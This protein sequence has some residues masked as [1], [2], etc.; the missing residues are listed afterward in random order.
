MNS[1]VLLCAI[2]G[3]DDAY[4]RESEQFSAIADGIAADRKRMRQRLTM[5]GVAAAVCLAVFGAVRLAPSVFRLFPPSE[6][7]GGQTPEVPASSEYT[8]SAVIRGE[9]TEKETA[10]SAVS[11]T[12]PAADKTESRTAPAG[13]DQ[14]APTSRPD[15]PAPGAEQ[16]PAETPSTTKAAE[17]TTA[18]LTTP[19]TEP[20]S[21]QPTAP[22]PG[23]EPGRSPGAVFTGRSVSYAE[24]RELFAH[25]IV[26]CY[27]D[28]FEGYEV[29]VVSR[30]GDI[31]ESGAFCLSVGYAFADGTIRLQD[32]DRLTGSSSASTLGEAYDYRGRTFYVQSPGDYGESCYRVGYYPTWDSG[33]AYEAVFDG[34]ADVYAIMDRIISVE[35]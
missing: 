15:R 14:T 20:A 18:N 10:G 4:L 8:V 29:G 1:R 34:D 19:H 33:I 6:I 35:I 9:T 23:G 22:Q 31:H 16:P 13:S 12:V 27:D 28:D 32:Q 26:P 5:I 7:P 21:E 17:P 11:P 30:N 24:A 3:I 2:A 25:P